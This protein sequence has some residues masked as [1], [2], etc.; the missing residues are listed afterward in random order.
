MKP[1]T[2]TIFNNDPMIKMVKIALF[3]NKRT[4][5]KARRF[6]NEKIEIKEVE[7]KNFCTLSWSLNR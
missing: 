4:T 6:S 1:K 7:L 5:P 3:Q 2:Q